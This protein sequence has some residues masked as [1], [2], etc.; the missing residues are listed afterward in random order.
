M[1]LACAVP[2]QVMA[3]SGTADSAAPDPRQAE[4]GAPAGKPR[5]E[6]Q[7]L[8]SEG[9][10]NRAWQLLREGKVEAAQ[11][12]FERGLAAHPSHHAARLAHGRV[13]QQLGRLEQARLEYE[14]ALSQVP[15]DVE[16]RMALID[17]LI[18]LERLTPAREQLDRLPASLARAHPALERRAAL[19]QASERLGEYRDAIAD[20]RKLLAQTADVARK[21]DIGDA[22]VG[23]ARKLDDTSLERDMLEAAIKLAPADLER[24]RTMIAFEQRTGRHEE[25]ARRALALAARSTDAADRLRAANLILETG[26]GAI[27][28]GYQPSALDELDRLAAAAGDSALRLQIASAHVARARSQA[29]LKVLSAVSASDAPVAQRQ[30]AWRERAEIERRAGRHE[31]R[32]QALQQLLALA[33]DD[34][35]ARRALADALIDAGRPAQAVAELEALLAQAPDPA[36]ERRLIDAHRL[37]GDERAVLRHYERLVE[38]PWLG[39]NARAGAHIELAALHLAASRHRDA[40]THYQRAATLADGEAARAGLAQAHAAL[41]EWPQAAREYA[42]LHQHTRQPIYALRTMRAHAAAGNVDEAVSWGERTMGVLGRLPKEEQGAF[43]VEYGNL[44]EMQAYR[45][46]R[47]GQPGR[48]ARAFELAIDSDSERLRLL[49]DLGYAYLA[50]G[51]VEG[52]QRS[53]RRSIDTLAAGADAPERSSAD[54]GLQQRLRRELRELNRRWSV[55]A[56]QSWRPRGSSPSANFSGFQRDGLIA[57]QGGAELA[58]RVLP[59]GPGDA[60]QPEVFARTLWSQRGDGLAIDGDSVQ[61]GVGLRFRPVPQFPVR[62]SAERLFAIGDRSTND[63]LLRASWGLS[64]G[65]EPPA[66]A[67]RWMSSQVYV[68]LGHFYQREGSDAL[69]AEVR[70]GLSLMTGEGWIL[71]PH[72]IVNGRSQ[73][74]DPTRQSWAEA[75][76]GVALRRLFGGSHY[77]A[78]R[79]RME[80]TLQYKLAVSGAGRSGL[81]IGGG[82]VW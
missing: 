63:W 59:P 52:A 57:S 77:E 15:D 28:Q 51:D 24:V 17:L 19:A 64:V 3:A 22:L 60:Q 55:S 29:A 21:L 56:Y 30:F 78:E 5:G 36:L 11:G 34:A 2:G 76:L 80:L 48:A 32:V 26:A 38:S 68:D 70:H 49:P 9:Y 12:Q 79:G 13:L 16:A 66:G 27:P 4:G 7:R 82:L 39:D 50:E 42:W 1:V 14:Q 67:R 45:L 44:L 8:V 41:A 37:M 72:L 58:F 62:V 74:P 40:L 53:F 23:L 65:D 47:S 43:R 54:T 10:F 35:A 69:Y 75:G 6:W 20:W 18:R 61:G 81:M 25:A 73:N 31:P 33:P 46:R 71:M